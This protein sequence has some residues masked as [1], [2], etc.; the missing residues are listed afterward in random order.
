MCITVGF[1]ELVAIGVIK[2]IVSKKNAI[3][4]NSGPCTMIS[5]LRIA[6]SASAIEDSGC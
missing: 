4:H 1:Y 5:R 2:P 6:F 3:Y